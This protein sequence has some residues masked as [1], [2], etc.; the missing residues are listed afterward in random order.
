M[1][2]SLFLERLENSQTILIQAIELTTVCRLHDIFCYPEK[3]SDRCEN[4][5]RSF[6]WNFVSRNVNY[7]RSAL[8]LIINLIIN[9]RSAGFL[10]KTLF[11]RREPWFVSS[12]WH[13]IK[14]IFFT[15]TLKTEI[16]EECRLSLSRV[17]IHSL[18]APIFPCAR[19]RPRTCLSF[20]ENST[21]MA[22]AW[23]SEL[24]SEIKLNQ[25]Y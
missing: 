19:N 6:A 20:H 16:E 1:F 22:R 4:P 23:R 14:Y 17:H 13:L 10:W 21:I 11:S 25:A 18:S 7:Y 24:S 9:M 3:E 2:G 8:I 15:W 5:F 12:P